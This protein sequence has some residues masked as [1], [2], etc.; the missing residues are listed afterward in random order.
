MFWVAVVP[1]LPLSGLVLSLSGSIH[2]RGD[3]QCCLEQVTTRVHIDAGCFHPINIHQQRAKANMFPLCDF[4][5]DETRKNQLFILHCAH[6]WRW[7]TKANHGKKTAWLLENLWLDVTVQR[8]FLSS[9][10]GLHFHVFMINS[11]LASFCG[12]LPLFQ[13]SAGV[14][15]LVSLDYDWLCPSI[16]LP[17]HNTTTWFNADISTKP[18]PWQCVYLSYISWWQ[19]CQWQHCEIVIM[20]LPGSRY[21]T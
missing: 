2:L 3:W 7:Y 6:K 1:L 18:E 10:A 11:F 5:I 17:Q 14:A 13:L 9:A 8:W 16:N 15:L 19:R 4:T 12:P 20:L 21:L